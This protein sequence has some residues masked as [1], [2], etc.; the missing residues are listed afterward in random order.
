MSE[1]HKSYLERTARKRVAD[2]LDAGSFHEILPPSER[3]FSP[4]LPVLGQPVAFD[5]G[6]VIGEGLLSGAKV[7]IA[8][9]EPAFMG[10]SVGE[11]HGAKMTGL[12]ERAL[13]QHPAAVLLLLDTG[14]VRLHEANAGLIAI[15]EIQRAVFDVRHAGIPVIVLIGGS[16]G[17]YGGIGIVAKCCDHMIISEEG[18]L[19]VSGPEVIEAAKG[20]EEF[21]ARDRALVWRTMGGKHRYLMGDADMIVPD[22]V[23]AFRDAAVSL[24]GA[25]KP[26][27]LE[28]IT[29][30]HQALQ[31]RMQRFSA[32]ADATQI[33]QALGVAEPKNVP[34][35]EIPEFLEMS[36]HVRRE[37]HA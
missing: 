10:G 8:A 3:H 21:D 18:R 24:L 15:S 37:E 28:T 25:S 2:L 9:Q 20:V 26:L 1:Q 4:H 14:G 13:V 34:L 7:L 30:E 32:C 36:A 22:D 19:S 17:C 16:N 12:L 29:Q 11:I 6:I 31:S 23:A 35:A 5:D 27:T 33:W